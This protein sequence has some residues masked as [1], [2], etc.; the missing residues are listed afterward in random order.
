[1]SK[2]MRFL[3]F[4][5]AIFFI[6]ISATI[7]SFN[8]SAEDT[9]IN[10]EGANVN[11]EIPDE[12]PVKISDDDKNSENL[13]KNIKY[14]NDEENKILEVKY[15]Q[16]DVS[17][18]L[19]NFKY[20]TKNEIDNELNNLRSNKT[21]ICNIK[22]DNV[23]AANI[24]ENKGCLMFVLYYKELAEE[25]H[26]IAYTVINGYMITVDY[27]TA[28][29]SLSIKDKNTFNSIVDSVSVSNIY[30]K[31]NKLDFSIIY[32][33]IITVAIVMGVVTVL[34]LIAYYVTHRSVNIG[35]H[36]Q[37]ADKYYDELQREGLME[38]E[39]IQKEE[40][41]DIV[42]EI[43]N[44]QPDPL[45][46]PESPDDFTNNIGSPSLIKDEW[47][48]IDLEKMF[49][50]TNIRVKPDITKTKIN[51]ELISENQFENVERISSSQPGRADSAKRYA[52]MF[53]GSNINHKQGNNPEYDA[54]MA[55]IE[56]RYRRRHE[57]KSSNR[58]KHRYN[59]SNNA[60]SGERKYTGSISR[61]NSSV[62]P[63]KSVH[64]TNRNNIDVF[65][66]FE[67]DSYW[68]KYR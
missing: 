65:G 35:T 45:I 29:E 21:N 39:E 10:I 44:I 57:N 67:T 27:T 60:K 54:K 64:N 19:Y 52:K 41:E 62:P 16:T 13:S 43:M 59:S 49:P 2:K 28:N 24:R 47:E 58:K 38:E 68:N 8:V 18:D 22:Y 23:T 25:N 14:T 50:K 7:F 12:L 9:Y 31:P 66:D 11:I 36:K 33:Q 56:E 53:M 1:M 40:K 46:P 6:I 51:G 34:V 48:D 4:S 30:E 61:K 63:K 17:K 42:E 15:E 3:P 20:L 37:V 5:I 26:A 32:K 55:E